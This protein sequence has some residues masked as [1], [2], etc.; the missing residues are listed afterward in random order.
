MKRPPILNKMKIQ[1]VKNLQITKL[2]ELNGLYPLIHL[3]RTISLHKNLLKI[4]FIVP[5]SCVVRR[6]W[7]YLA[8]VKIELHNM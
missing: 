8:R 5:L 7:Q 6:I 3:K 1:S 2:I 4:H